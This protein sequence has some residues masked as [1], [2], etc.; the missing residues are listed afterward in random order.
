MKT[1][2]EI[3]VE[4]CR[5]THPHMESPRGQIDL[6]KAEQEYEALCAVAEALKLMQ[7]HYTDLGKSNPGFMGKLALKDYALWNNALLAMDHSLANLV[8]VR[9]PKVKN[10]VK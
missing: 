2:F 1:P 9:Q 10:P 8:A 7:A 3:L 4:H 6:R 5:E